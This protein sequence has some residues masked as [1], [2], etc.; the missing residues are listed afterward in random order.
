ML[1]RTSYKDF[2]VRYF[3]NDD[4][5]LEMQSKTNIVALKP[6]LVQNRLIQERKVKHP[7]INVSPSSKKID[8]LKFTYQT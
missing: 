3:Q 4:E 8:E 2:S 6:V 7:T 5:E 1:N